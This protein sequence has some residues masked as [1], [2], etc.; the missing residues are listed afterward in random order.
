MQ[1][2]NDDQTGD[3]VVG[4]NGNIAQA[5]E[6]KTAILISLFT[7]READEGDGVEPNA[8]RGWWGDAYAEVANDKIGSR[9]WLLRQRRASTSDTPRLAEQYVREALQWMIDDG[10]A[11]DVAATA[12][13]IRA[14]VLKITVDIK[15]PDKVAPKWETVWEGEYGV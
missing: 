2:N 4:D 3:L 5:D 1:F 9:L 8:R 12:S 13:Y 11:D 6:L 7:D 15:K 14:D 10:V